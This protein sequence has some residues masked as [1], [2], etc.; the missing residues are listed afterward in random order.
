M[1]FG[2]WYLSHLKLPDVGSNF[3]PLQS[4]WLLVGVP[5]LALDLFLPGYA[6]DAVMHAAKASCPDFDGLVCLPLL[7]LL[8]DGGNADAFWVR[9]P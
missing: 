8:E 9:R 6:S 7:R 5:E 3:G 1:Q 2:W 4:G